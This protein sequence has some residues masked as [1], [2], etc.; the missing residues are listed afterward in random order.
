MEASEIESSIKNKYVH[1]KNV[2]IEQINSQLEYYS[3]KYCFNSK[4]N[5]SNT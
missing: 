2:R 1:N 5:F 3:Y 4:D